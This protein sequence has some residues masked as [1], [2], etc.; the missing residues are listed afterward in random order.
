M[1][2]ELHPGVH[3][4]AVLMSSHR[5]PLH[6]A[7]PVHVLALAPLDLIREGVGSG[8]SPILLALGA[9]LLAAVY[10]AT[11]SITTPARG[12]G[13]RDAALLAIM[14]AC[15]LVQGVAEIWRTLLPVSYVGQM[16]RLV[17]IL[18]AATGV[19]AALVA[20]TTRRFA[21]TWQRRAGV[22]FLVVA[23]IAWV[24]PGFDLRTLTVLAAAAALATAA[25]AVAAWRGV[26]GSRAVTAVLVAFVVAGFSETGVFLDRELFV[27]LTLLTLV[28]LV[29]HVQQMRRVHAEVIA[30]RQQVQQLEL[31]VLR[32]RLTPH[33]LL[34]MLNA[35][36][37]WIEE[38]PTTAVR[39]VGL[40]GEEFNRLV[41][42]EQA[43]LIAVRDELAACERLLSLMSL[44]SGRT[45]ALDAAGVT[46]TLSVPPGVLHT[47]VENALTHGQYRRGAVFTVRQNIEHGVAVLAFEAPRGEPV[48]SALDT[49]PREHSTE[50]F[51]LH[52]IRARLRA[53]FGDDAALEYGPRDD[54]GWRTVL[55]LGAMPA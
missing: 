30:A 54:G 9:L 22:S 21:P 51:G 36:T 26:P 40:L 11:I 2:A 31:E 8:S 53:A 34:N 20:Y 33:W 46:P 5:G 32:Q 44:R 38:E 3:Q 27:G 15:A 48:G 4:L 47:L 1:H 29:D 52:Y 49:P 42:P 25:A 7:M 6:V 19:G 37:A 45:F 41:Q 43:S 39:M 18:L 28:L 17:I 10:F 35:V 13:R 16:W 55:R 14:I 24:L 50:G 23:G 12:A